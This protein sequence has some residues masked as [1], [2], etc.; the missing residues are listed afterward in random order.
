MKLIIKPLL[1]SLAVSA[2]FSAGAQAEQQDLAKESYAIGAS[3]GKYLTG[4]MASQ[5][6]F[7]LDVDLESLIAGFN[8][9]VN[10][11]EK[12][13][14]DTLVGVLNARAQL[15]NTRQDERQAALLKQLSEE[16]RDYLATNRDKPGVTVTESGLQYEVLVKGEGVKPAREDA[17]T[18]HYKGSFINGNVFQD[19]HESGEP[20]RVALINSIAGW[21]EGLQLMPVGSTYRFTIPAELA[22][23]QEGMG[24][25][26]GGSAVIFEIELIETKKPGQAHEGVDMGK[27]MGMSMGIVTSPTLTHQ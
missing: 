18:V 11:V 26:P 3:M 27:G 17:V 7:G 10:G 25:I 1:V 21:E 15:L 12:M 8:D 22:Y 24:A 2:C 14:N 4:Q 5:K 13:D 9:A 19:T 6:E 16:S 20:Q 23:G